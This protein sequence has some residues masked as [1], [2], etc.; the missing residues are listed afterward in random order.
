MSLTDDLH[1]RIESLASDLQSLT[2]ESEV[3]Y[4]ARKKLLTVTMKANAALE[5]PH[6]MIWRMIM[7]V[8]LL[9]LQRL[10]A[11]PVITKCL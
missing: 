6:E 1:Q 10:N 9:Q 4:A 11:S 3:D 7:S 8:R 2:T 5:A